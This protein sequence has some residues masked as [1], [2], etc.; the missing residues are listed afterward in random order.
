MA[1]LS[2]EVITLEAIWNAS[3]VAA[4][5]RDQN[6]LT[7]CRRIEQEHVDWKR[8]YTYRGCPVSTEWPAIGELGRFKAEGVELRFVI[9]RNR[10]IRVLDAAGT[11]HGKVSVQPGMGERLYLIARTLLS[12]QTAASSAA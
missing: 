5:S 9:T 12:P 7:F 3:A 6:L 1:E 4:L 11:E 2:P 10:Q 8:P